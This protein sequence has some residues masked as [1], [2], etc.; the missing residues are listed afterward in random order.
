MTGEWT[1][2]EVNGQTI[3]A[4]GY[5]LPFPSTDRLTA[6][7][8]EFQTL[9]FFSC[10]EGEEKSSG[11]VVAVYELVTATGQ[12]KQT[13]SYGGSFEYNNRTGTLTLKAF[14]KS[15]DGD[16]VGEEFTIRPDIPLFGTYVLTLQRTSLF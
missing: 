11:R 2:I 14:D 3:P 9:K 15:V 5:P 7:A 1:L 10:K 8:L 4:S 13:K 16:R 6:G 12:P